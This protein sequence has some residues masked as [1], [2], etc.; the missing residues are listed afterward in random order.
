V[1]MEA[2]MEAVG[3]EVEGLAE[4]ATVEVTAV[5]MVEVGTV[6]AGSVVGL[7]AVTRAV[8]E[9]VDSGAAA[10]SKAGWVIRD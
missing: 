8:M 9:A 7:R 5:E 4:E 1:A 10:A 6:V 2:A 3:S